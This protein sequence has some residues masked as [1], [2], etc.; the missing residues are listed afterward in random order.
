MRST[1]AAGVAIGKRNRGVSF[2][3]MTVPDRKLA[4]S[5]INE[6]MDNFMDSS[7]IITIKIGATP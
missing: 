2:N 7:G 4:C 5:V 6:P 1:N 3:G